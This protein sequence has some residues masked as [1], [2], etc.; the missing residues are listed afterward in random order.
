[1]AGPRRSS[2]LEQQPLRDCGAQRLP[3]DSGGQEPERSPAVPGRALFPPDVLRGLPWSK[4]T[5]AKGRETQP[6]PWGPGQMGR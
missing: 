4:A 2:T 1:M 3:G 6:G 5:A